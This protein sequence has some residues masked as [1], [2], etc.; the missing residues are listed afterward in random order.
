MSAQD[1][2]SFAQPFP[3]PILW[4]RPPVRYLTRAARSRRLMADSLAVAVIDYYAGNT[5]SVTRA[6]EKLG[7]KIGRVR[8]DP[9]D[10]QHLKEC[11]SALATVD[12]KRWTLLTSATYGPM[13]PG[14]ETL[15]EQLFCNPEAVIQ[16]VV[17]E[18]TSNTDA[19]TIRD[20]TTVR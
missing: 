14:G 5:P 13:T 7:A 6:L 4:V 16:F 10:Q 2:T 19:S 1:V 8:T 18:K 12:I 17:S 3:V 15:M 11:L 20:H 9:F